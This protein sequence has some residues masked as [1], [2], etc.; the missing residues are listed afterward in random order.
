MHHEKHVRKLCP[1]TQVLR[2]S[3][4]SN[5]PI[6]FAL[7]PQ[8]HP[9]Q[10]KAQRPRLSVYIYPFTYLRTNEHIKISRG[11]LY[12]SPGL[13]CEWKR[14]RCG[15][16]LHS[17]NFSMAPTTKESEHLTNTPTQIKLE[18][19]VGVSRNQNSWLLNSPLISPRPGTIHPTPGLP[20]WPPLGAWGQDR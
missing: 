2:T 6:A 10:N 11:S 9:G 1:T 8:Q 18:K 19:T 3:S 14:K 13:P 4:Q 16:P 20:S 12:H 7:V 5:H 17:I 15:A